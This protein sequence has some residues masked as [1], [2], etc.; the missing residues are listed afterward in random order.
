VELHSVGRERPQ[1]VVTVSFDVLTGQLSTGM[2]DT[3]EAISPAQVRRLACD[4]QI[5][6]A[7][8]GGDGQVLDLGKSRRLFTGA[9]RRALALR[10]GGCAFPGCSRPARWCEGH[11]ILPASLAGPTSVD[12][13]VLLC[14]PHHRLVHHED[15]QIRL[16]PDRRPDF[17]PPSHVDPTRR[18]RRNIY[19]RRP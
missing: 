4:A 14:G 16:G 6:P 17:I 15:W 12:N 8:L 3:G 1:L 7:V 18:P 11:H 13:G 9:V 2:L 10:D 5:I 19:H